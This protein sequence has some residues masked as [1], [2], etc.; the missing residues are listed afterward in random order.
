MRTMSVSAPCTCVAAR[1][2]PRSQAVATPGRRSVASRAIEFDSDTLTIVFAAVAGVGL[3]I[4]APVFYAQSEKRDKERIESIRQMNRANLK[5]TGQLLS[6]VRRAF[7][8]SICD[9][10]PVR[11]RH[12]GRRRPN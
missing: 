3:G 1:A 12:S 7:V 9:A 4:G 5:A 2:A 8:I 6:E 11:E 10:Q